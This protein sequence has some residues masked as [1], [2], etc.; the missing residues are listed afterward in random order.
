MARSGFRVEDEGRPAV[1]CESLEAAEAAT[2][3][4][5]V[6]SW[7]P[8]GI[9]L[10]VLA[11]FAPALRC[12]FIV[13][14]DDDQNL[15]NNVQYRGLSLAHLHWMFTTFHGGHYQPLSWIT[16]AIDY[17]LWGMQPRGY[18]LT[19]VMLHAANALLVYALALALLP[20]KAFHT[21]ARDAGLSPRTWQFAATQRGA[22]HRRDAARR[23]ASRRRAAAVAA[24]CFAIHPL[25][26]ESVAWVTERR[27]VLSAFFLLLTVLAYIRMVDARPT[28]AWRIWL[29]LSLGSFVLSLLSKAWGMTLPVVLVALDAYPLRRF[30]SGRNNLRLVLWEKVPFLLLAGAAMVLAAFAQLTVSEIHTLGQHSITGRLMQAAYGLVFY[31]WKTLLP[32]NLSPLYPLR[33]D[34]TPT[35]APYLLCA[36]TVLAMTLTVVWG[37]RR[38]PWALAAWTVYVVILSPVLGFLQTGPQLV[39]DRYTYLACLPFALLAGAAVCRWPTLRRPAGAAVIAAL[40]VTLAALTWRQT[41]EWTNAFTLWDH[42]LRVDPSNYVANVNR[43]WLQLQ[44]G[45]V[46]GALT[47][48]D[49]ALRDNPQFAIAYRSRGFA[50]HQRG[51]LRGAIADYTTSLQLE[52][53]AASYLNRGLARHALGDSDGALADYSESLRL[54]G[55]DPQAYN[56]RGMLRRDRE[57]L[58][59]AISDFQKALE[60]APPQWPYRGQT[61]DNLKETQALAGRSSP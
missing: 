29:A 46:D 17:L 45:D 54:N 56:N 4:S 47:Y 20:R 12:D 27:D 26:V 28:P 22:D 14:W 51:D 42:A 57:D 37:R 19:N 1:S 18:H 8:W 38:W 55:A 32:V 50:R 48:Y 31:V 13:N 7:V 59:G 21:A 35:A 39:A 41:S 33:P 43:G 23:A 3:F 58:A 52:P 61:E 40:L 5:H 9:A 16:F 24:L 25:R 49:A 10:V 30:G 53:H 36:F 34:F 60:V 2:T 11:C 44:R 6:V 15:L